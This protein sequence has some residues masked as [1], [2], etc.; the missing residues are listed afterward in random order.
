MDELTVQLDWKHE[1]EIYACCRTGVLYC[2]DD[3]FILNGGVL[4]GE[5][6]S[7]NTMNWVTVYGRVLPNCNITWCPDPTAV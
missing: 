6:D 1:R 5:K 7:L 2:E 4:N 3:R